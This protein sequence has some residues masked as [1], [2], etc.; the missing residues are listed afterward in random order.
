MKN[1]LQNKHVT[2]TALMAVAVVGILCFTLRAEA[3][4]FRLGVQLENSTC[5]TGEWR[6]TAG[7]DRDSDDLRGHLNLSVGPNGGCNGQ[8]YT[9]DAQVDYQYEVRGPWFVVAGAGYD[10]RNR[11]DEYVGGMDVE[12]DGA[13]FFRGNSVEAVSLHVG[14]GYDCG[15]NC[16]IQAT[17]NV[18]DNALNSGGNAFPIWVTGSYQ[19]GEIEFNA[20]ANFEMFQAG[21]SW[22]LGRMTVTG[23]VASG[24]QK[25][26]NPVPAMIVVNGNPA[27][28]AGAPTTT[29]NLRFE[30][31]LL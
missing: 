9:I 7:W 28:L 21:A 26:E 17:Y 15:A 10:R 29:Y 27:Y 19:F 1:P 3:D 16:Y 13:K 11:P 8:G 12:N 6:G 31:D 20:S 2:Y 25:L 4:E 23:G 14:P 30:F 5:G 18:V 24:Y 22:D